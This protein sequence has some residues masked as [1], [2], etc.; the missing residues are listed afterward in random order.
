MNTIALHI[1][2]RLRLTHVDGRKGSIAVSVA[3]ASV[4]VS[5]IVMLITLAITNGFK[6]G[7]IDTIF[8]FDGGMSTCN[9][10]GNYQP[11]SSH[12]ADIIAQDIVDAY[13][14]ATV[15]RLSS[16]PVMLK[17]PDNF[18][19]LSIRGYKPG[20]DIEFLKDLIVEGSP[21]VVDTLMLDDA[22][23]IIVV[24]STTAKALNLSTGDRI[25][26]V[27]I[28]YNS[29]IR[30]R[31]PRIAALYSS[32]IATY[33]ESVA[34][35]NISTVD[36]I[37]GADADECTHIYA[38][39]IP[40]KQLNEVSDRINLT[41]QKDFSSGH[42]SNNYITIPVTSSSGLFINWLSLLD[43]NVVVIISL[44]SAIALFTLIATIFI[45]ILERIRFIGTLKT[46]GASDR[47]VRQ[48]FVAMMS[49][50]VI[51]GLIIGNVIA[52]TIIAVQ[53]ATHFLPL[54]PESYYFNYVPMSLTIKAWMLVNIAALVASTL[55]MI[56]PSALISRLKPASTMRFE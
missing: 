3:T 25:N 42:T 36:A 1:A 39:N 14:S 6:S 49:R 45:L 5:V 53:S 31:N 48:I 40:L 2:R 17:T 7:L 16:V 35:T 44:M 50:I 37:S 12:D 11:I 8:Q 19:A 21:N 56:I 46:I 18:E 4:V 54:D 55:A 32:N 30:L 34:F 41:L 47:L 22:P 20:S 38:S 15:T 29:R 33:D 10:S 52:V 23:D 27:Y 26:T 43:T 28:D 24:S 9:I 13:P 51:R